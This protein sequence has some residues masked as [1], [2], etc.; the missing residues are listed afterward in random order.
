MDLFAHFLRFAAIVLVALGGTG[1]AFADEAPGHV[2]AAA[3]LRE[4]RS[5]DGLWRYSLD[6][7]RAS[8]AGIHGEE[9]YANQRRY[10]DVD[11]ARAMRDD[12]SI[13]YEFDMDAAPT[14]LL[15]SSWLTHSP[16]M[17]HYQG[18]V[19]YQRHFTYHP[20]SGK[21]VFVRF[22]AA[23]QSLTV[24]VNG[25]LAGRHRGGFTPALFEIGS[26]LRDGD[27]RIT[28]GVD[29]VP[30][31]HDLPSATTDW[32][33]YG[34]ITRP[35]RLI[36]TPATFVDDAWVRLTDDGRIAVSVRLDGPDAAGHRLDFAVP[37]L[38]IAV[39]GTADGK[40][41]W[42]GSV[43]PGPGLR[44][45]SPDDPALYDVT[46]RAGDDEWH[47]RIGFRT[48]RV[49]GD[50]LELNGQP[51]FL[52]G[53]CMHEEELGTNPTRAMTEAA[54]RALMLEARDGLHANY[55]RLA[56][57]P[58]GEATLRLA[59]S[60]GLIVWSEIPVFWQIGFDDPGT[61]A[62]ART[63]L[64]DMILRD[65]N[66]AA[67]GIWSIGNETPVTPA[68]NAFMRQLAADA[69]A[70]DP[71]RPVSAALLTRRS[72]RDGHPV[73]TLD[74]PLQDALDIVAI[75]SYVGWY[76]GDPLSAV[77]NIEWEGLPDKPVVLSEFGSAALAGFH[78]P[79]HG[80]FTEEFQ[81]DYYRATLA[82]ASRMPSLAGMSAWVLKDFRSPRRQ[83]PLYQQGWNR[84]GLLSPTGARKQAFGVLADYYAQRAGTRPISPDIST[85][86][87]P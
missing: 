22:G 52:R 50:H 32:E 72:D 3:D 59:D 10:A 58:H 71:T 8:L 23:N 36:E 77:S 83:H 80:K 18:L 24:Y 5:L 68:R 61:L 85:R 12:P 74:D 62:S 67:I 53:I 37:A 40:G 78:D 2:M 73:L 38:G 26:L 55:L 6:P 35:V 69:H 64:R 20:V 19:W 81:A 46:I 28:A 60:M 48:F 13:F 87:A 47:D 70:I 56:H 39:S 29:S 79:A 54:A 43:D 14:A 76:D 30:G 57:Y 1:A 66:R 49:V 65:R 63:M 45:W 21:R 4:G 7:Y 51:I 16:E 41:R 82:M 31:P 27:N 75:N 86:T 84:K 15:P 17:R 33:N 34:G 44:R 25:K 42:T 9:P 11:V